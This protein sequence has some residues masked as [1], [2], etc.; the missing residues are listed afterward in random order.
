[1]APRHTSAIELVRLP[2]ADG[3]CCPVPDCAGSRWWLHRCDAA[4]D[5]PRPGVPEQHTNGWRHGRPR[6]GAGL[7]T[8]SP[9]AQRS[10]HRVEQLL[11]QRLPAVPLLHGRACADDRRTQR[12]LPVRSCLQA[13][14]VPWHCD[15]AVLLL[16]LRSPCPFPLSHPGTDGDGRIDLP[17]RRELHHLWRQ[18]H[19]HHGW[20]V[21]VLDCAVVRHPRTWSFC[22]G[23]GDG[24]VPQLDGHP[25]RARHALSWHRADLR[26]AGRAADV[27]DLDG[28]NPVHLRA[29]HGH[30]RACSHG[31]LGF[32]VPAEPR[33]HDR[34][35]VRLSPQRWRRQLLGNVLRPQHVL[36]HR[37]QWLRVG[38]FRQQRGEAQ[39]HRRVAGHHVFRADG[40]RLHDARQPARHRSAVEPATAAVLLSPALHVDDGG[41][42]RHS[43]LRGEGHPHAGPHYT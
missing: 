26:G 34:H 18:C 12:H 33:I 39:S 21:L 11:V 22:S 30:H 41:H 5:S 14:R 28:Q 20:R 6:H 9:I 4:G 37:R 10:D 32:P 17:L 40:S 35:E 8:R 24:Q 2:L 38:R 27:A 29:H 31:L 23:A 43:A 19:Q 16:G 42:R 25:A 36:E 3:A 15:S 7:P 13:R 1:M